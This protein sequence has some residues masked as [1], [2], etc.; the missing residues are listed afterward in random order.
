MVC[1][2]HYLKNLLLIL[3]LNAILH[4][5]FFTLESDGKKP[6]KKDEDICGSD[7]DD[8]DDNDVDDCDEKD[9]CVDDSSVGGEVFMMQW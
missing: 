1:R 3:K 2:K 4:Y 9:E 8:F 5:Q 7:G 6:E